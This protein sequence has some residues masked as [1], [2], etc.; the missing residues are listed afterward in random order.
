MMVVK[1]RKQEMDKEEDW[2]KYTEMTGHDRQTK[3]QT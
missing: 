3:S 1:A 2:G